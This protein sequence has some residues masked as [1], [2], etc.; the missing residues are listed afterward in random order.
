MTPA[1]RP[2]SA[3]TLIVVLLFAAM[4][5]GTH[6]SVGF[7]LRVLPIDIAIGAALLYT[8][9]ARRF[10]IRLPAG[11]FVLLVLI[12]LNAAYE[13]AS[14]IF[15]DGGASENLSLG[16]ALVRNAALVLV[17]AQLDYDADRTRA[18]I[19]A[20]GAAFSVI[21]IGGFLRATHDSAR[22]LSS[23]AFDNPGIFYTVDNLQIRL[24]GL[25]EDPNFFFIINLIP[26][27]MG[28]SLI[29]QR[30]RLWSVAATA[31]IVVAS[32][33][34]FSR[35]GALLLALLLAFLF[36]V[37]LTRLKVGRIFLAVAAMVA[38]VLGSQLL[39]ETYN[40]PD[41]AQVMFSRFE[42]AGETG[43]SGRAYL[44]SA[45]WDGFTQAVVF[46]QGGRY[47]LRAFGH[48]AHNDYLEMLSSHGLVGF[49]LMTGMWLYIALF[50]AARSLA[51]RLAPLFGYSALCF[52]SLL[53]AS[54]FFTIYY[55]PYIWFV[56]ALVFSAQE[57]E[58][59]ASR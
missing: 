29:R 58:W 31:V 14:V 3:G 22:I 42:R 6:F 7:V 30:A 10:V 16:V 13:L 37:D 56:V 35:S 21:A 27:L 28:V 46:G 2:T 9:L 12:A 48:Y 54:F 4:N 45:V 33:L 50:I 24:Q 43:G 25:R 49:A 8:L 20:A 17:I 18:W 11:L 19:T 23:H 59:D 39:A 1:A 53:G 57:G 47:S 38:V 44:W 5:L 51:R 40:L 52:L 55:N 32:L 34:T 15:I 36:A 26:L 41:I